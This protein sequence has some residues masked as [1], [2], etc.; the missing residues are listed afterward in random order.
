M[1]KVWQLP[2]MSTQDCVTF[3]VQMVMQSIRHFG[4]YISFFSN[5][6]VFISQ[7][8]KKIYVPYKSVHEQSFLWDSTFLENTS[9][10]PKIEVKVCIYN[11]LHTLIDLTPY[12][13]LR[14]RLQTWKIQCFINLSLKKSY[15]SPFSSK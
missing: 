11:C 3:C 9:K 4:F 5:F 7:P 15:W 10:A 6:H 14:N 2:T 13:K 8:I 12:E 1:E